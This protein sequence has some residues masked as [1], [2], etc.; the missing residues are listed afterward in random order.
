MNAEDRNLGMDRPITRRDFVSGVS[1]AIGGSLVASKVGQARG[2]VDAAAAQPVE[3]TPGNYPPMRNGLRG[4]HPGSFESAHAARTAPSPPAA[5]DT[6]ET[7][8]LIVVG[9]GLSGLAAAYYYR[10]R[11]GPAARI[12]VLDNHDDF[13]GH[14]KRNEYVYNGRTLMTTGGS[15]YMVAPSTWTHEARQILKDLGIEKGHPTHRSG[16]NVFRSMGLGPAVFFRK[17]KYGEDKL[18]T[19][20]SLNN[21][22][23]EFMAKTPFPPQVQAD[24]VR[25]YKGK[26]DYMAGQSADEKI[27]KLQRMTY[28]DY[29]LNVVKVHPDVPPLL[30][31]VW[32]LS[33]DMV[34]AWFAYYRGRPGFDGLGVER[35][36]EGPESPS[37]ALT[38][39]GC[40]PATRT[41]RD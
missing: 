14:A 40:R 21:P 13:G 6:R 34:T 16:G 9:G 27:A 23:P 10:K 36:P 28:R 15:A 17:E 30:N 24:L 41:S 22:S 2:A 39:S 8:D 11:S 26:T 25:L 35:P 20:G 38:T 18:V 5:E 33:T 32:A 3:P 29:L 31:G 19:G 37:T 4:A 7:Y 1:V 12:L